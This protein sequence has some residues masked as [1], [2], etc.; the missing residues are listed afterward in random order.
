MLRKLVF[1][2]M[3]CAV[4][5]SLCAGSGYSQ[6]KGNLTGIEPTPINDTGKVA[7][8]SVSVKEISSTVQKGA[9]L[10]IHGTE[11]KAGETATIFLQLRDAVGNP[12]NNGVCYL[13]LFAPNK[14]KVLGKAPML[15][16]A[17]SDGLYF[18]D[19]NLPASTGL[20]MVSATCTYSNYIRH[21]YTLTA[22]GWNPF[23]YG[24]GDELINGTVSVGGA[25]QGAVIQLNNLMDWAY[26]YQ[27][28]GAGGT[29]AVNSTFVWNA[30]DANCKVNKT[31][32]QEL[33]FYYMG[34]TYNPIVMNFYAWNWVSSAW[35]SIGSLSTVGR[36]STTATT[37]VEDYFGAKMSLLNHTAPDGT[38]KIM[39]YAGSGTTFVVWYDWMGLVASTNNTAITELKGSGE[40]HLSGDE[41]IYESCSIMT[42]KDQYL[43]NSPVY[44]SYFSGTAPTRLKIIQ[45]N[46]STYY[47]S[48]LVN[49]TGVFVFN[50]TSP[51]ERQSYLLELLC[52]N[53]FAH[54]VIVIDRGFWDIPFEPLIF[55]AI[56]FILVIFAILFFSSRR[57]D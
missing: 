48:G 33:S 54:K 27:V 44:V 11:Y 5:V 14:T 50:F 26:V 29:K 15:Y 9:G 38:V 17:Y 57:H 18:Y 32:T 49:G 3:I 24:C 51:A 6:D 28:A 56:G 35:D 34:E 47:D 36:A 12:I 13:D 4:L 23:E 30:S 39:V 53:S 7:I 41:G 42:D 19:Y 8:S 31:N 43:P 37:G 22:G 55:L 16:T 25:L 40:I 10:T 45:M 46:G 2:G 20:Y 1:F 21:Y 52:G